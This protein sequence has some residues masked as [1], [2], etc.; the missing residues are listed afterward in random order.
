VTTR[1]PLNPNYTALLG[2]AIYTFAYYEWAVICLIDHFEFDFVHRYC[3]EEKMTSGDVLC[4]LRKVLK[5]AATAYTTVSREE[6]ET[7]CLRFEYLINKRNALIHAHP[8]T[9]TDG[10]QILYRQTNIVHNSPDFKWSI[11]ELKQVLREF[12]AAACNANA[13]LDRLC[14]MNTA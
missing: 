8:V 9:D 13:L 14:S 6:I 10:S 7:C 12:D 2:V 5:D 4:V 3:R 11:D 1:V